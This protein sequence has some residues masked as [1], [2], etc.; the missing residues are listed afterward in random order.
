MPAADCWRRTL[1]APGNELPAVL[2]ELARHLEE[3]LGL[4]HCGFCCLVISAVRIN[5]GCCRGRLRVVVL[6]ARS[7]RVGGELESE[8]GCGKWEIW[9]CG[10]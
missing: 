3:L 6:L 8:V 5:S 1:A 10:R 9:S 2:D 7:M 4:V